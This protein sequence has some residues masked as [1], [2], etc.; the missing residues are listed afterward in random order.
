MI[1]GFAVYDLMAWALAAFFTVGAIG[2]WL[3]PGHVRADY[4]RWG[5]PDWS[6]RVTGVLE[7]VV[8]I[9]LIAAMSRIWGMA[10]GAA[11]MVAT[12]ATLLRHQEFRHALLPAGVLMMIAITALSA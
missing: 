7:L 3:A 4:I 1:Y 6:H 5:C 12:I 10:L 11:I 9:L 8:A 2:N